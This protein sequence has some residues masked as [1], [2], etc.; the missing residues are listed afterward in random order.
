M[1]I[2]ATVTSKRLIPI[3]KI[4]PSQVEKDMAAQEV[5]KL[6]QLVITEN[7]N[8][9]FMKNIKVSESLDEE[10]I[11]DTVACLPVTNNYTVEKESWMS[12]KTSGYRAQ[13][14]TKT[15]RAKVNQVEEFSKYLISPLRK[16]YDVFFRSTMVAFKAIRC[17]LKLKISK[18]APKNW[19]EKRKKMDDR[20]TAFVRNSVSTAS[21]E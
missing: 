8:E 17:W 9:N 15:V 16:R 12:K 11:E 21:I 6:H 19:S 1:G 20:I 5:V 14:A 10:T 18:E 4:S 3:D 13:K 2:K 7:K